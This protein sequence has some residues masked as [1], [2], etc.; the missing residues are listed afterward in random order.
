MQIQG[1]KLNIIPLIPEIAVEAG[2]LKQ[3]GISIADAIIAAS[4][5]STGAAIVT[6]DPHFTG[7][8]IEVIRY[9]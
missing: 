1:S 2:L 8:G 6:K 7:M 5:R 3:P 9:P 4:A